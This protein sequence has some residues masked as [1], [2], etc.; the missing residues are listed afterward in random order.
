MSMKN[1]L[2]LALREIYDAWEFT[3]ADLSEAQITT[4]PAP[5][6]WSVQDDLAHLWAWQQRS[7]A[8]LEAALYDRPPVM[9]AFMDGVELVTEDNVDEL[10]ARIYA[11]FGEQPW[12]QVYQDWRSGFLKF[13]DTAA[14][15]SEKDLLDWDKYPWL[16]G[17]NLAAILIG[18]YEHHQE[19]LEVLL[20]RR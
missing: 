18:S 4:A 3:L 11:A 2:I 12:P 17:F 1:H 20:A 5:G 16:G 19:H 10:N 14:Q 6:I 7:I 15:I 9:P 8:R 13:L